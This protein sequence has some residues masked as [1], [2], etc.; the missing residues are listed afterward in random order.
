M[1]TNH[2]IRFKV[3]K[4]EHD[5]IKNKAQNIGLSIKSYILHLLLRTNIR[6]E[7]E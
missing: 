7:V 3:T 5:K 4:E 6:V 2:E 1:K